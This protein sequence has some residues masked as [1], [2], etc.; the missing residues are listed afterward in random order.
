MPSHGATVAGGRWRTAGTVR[1][2]DVEFA[3]LEAD[4]GR[5]AG[6]VPPRLPGHRPHVAPPAAR[7]GRRRLPRRRAVHPWLRADRRP[8]RRPVPDRRAGRRRQ[9]APRRAR[10]RR[11]RRRS[12]VTTG[13]RS[14]AYGAAVHEPDRW[15]RVVGAGRA[16]GRRAG[17]GVRSTNLDQLQRSWYMFLFQHPLADLVVPADDFAFDRP[18]VGAVVA[19]LR[20]DAA[21]DVAHV[22]QALAE[23]ATLPAA[24]GYYR[25]TVGN[26]PRDPRS[27]SCQAATAADPAAADA[28]PPRSRRRLRRR[29]GAP[30]RAR[31]EARSATTTSRSR[32]STAAGTSC[33]SSGP[34]SSTTGSWSSSRDGRV[35]RCPTASSSSSR[36]SARRAGWSP[37]CCRARRPRRRHGLH[38]GRSRRSRRRRRRARRTT[39]RVSWH[40]DDRD[41]ADPD[42][43]GRRRGDRAHGRLVAGRLAADHRASPT[44]A[45]T[46]R[47]CARVRL[48]ERRPR[49]R[50]RAARAVRGR[51]AA[52]RGASSW[53]SC[54]D[55]IEAMFA[56]GWTDGLPVVPPTE[57]RVLRDARRARPRPADESWRPCRPT[58]S[59]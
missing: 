24:L 50:R 22:R 51:P 55:D 25:A 44:S 17:H 48:A 12:S 26:G 8:R 36:R 59:T 54:E 56:R 1:V 5:A 19:R 37:R 38:A 14:A 39:S 46:C 20:A 11:R 52:S 31:G 6:A 23:P 18:A 45:P 2:G 43:R 53:P 4:G 42:A 29:R 7:A 58:S 15:A 16:A 13:A 30:R 49:P 34:T 27:T 10:R 47:R 3:Y 9:R 35:R 32:S 21:D 33:T 28:V 40:H 57:E 41:G